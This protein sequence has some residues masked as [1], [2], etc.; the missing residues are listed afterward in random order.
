MRQAIAGATSLGTLVT[1]WLTGNKKWYGWAVGLANQVV[2]L[3]FILVFAAYGLLPLFV[4]L[5]VIY[6]RNLIK[7]KREAAVDSALPTI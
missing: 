3:T 5:V 1:M 2:W 4:A 7:W 6:S